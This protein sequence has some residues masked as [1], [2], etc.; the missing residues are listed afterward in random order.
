[1][2]TTITI[3]FVLIFTVLGFTQNKVDE[4]VKNYGENEITLYT[5]KG[6]LIGEP[7]VRRNSD[8][9][10]YSI[11]ISGNTTDSSKIAELFLTLFKD[12]EEEGYK[13]S[14]SNPALKYDMSKRNIMYLISGTNID[15]GLKVEY[16]KDQY[17]FKASAFA[18]KDNSNSNKVVNTKTFDFQDGG[19]EFINYLNSEDHKDSAII[20]EK[21]KFYKFEIEMID[22]SRL[23]GSKSTK[24]KF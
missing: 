18:I 17:L 11:K 19:V 22:K 1:M 9:L 8:K 20:K 15:G 10:P 24:F 23:G 12:K 3:L 14:E 4:L 13:L 16:S 7:V 2:R 5:T 6:E 21:D